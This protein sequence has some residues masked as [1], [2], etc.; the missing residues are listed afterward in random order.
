MR[1]LIP[2][3]LAL[4]MLTACGTEVVTTSD[5]ASATSESAESVVVT[6]EQP[7][8]SAVP[9]MTPTATPESKA[10]VPGQT[11]ISKAV[12]DVPKKEQ[13]VPMATAAPT[14]SPTPVATEAPAPAK[15]PAP[16]AP[17][18]SQ[19]TMTGGSLPLDVAT[20]SDQWWAIDSSDSAYW[21]VADNINAIRAAG[22]LGA[23][24]VDSGLSSAASSR[25]EDF[26]AGGA[27]DHSGMTTKS[28]IC[29]SGGI[30]SASAVCAAWESSSAHYANIMRTDI[31]SMGIGCWFCYYDGGYFT[32]W[33]VTF[34]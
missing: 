10:A 26:V 15:T 21:A 9:T 25:C 17:A 27:F 6:T 4:A 8:H 22:G 3:F 13:L 32:Y 1:K 20:N 16:A 24:S 14:A 23:L 5:S 30:T 33:V 29:A 11:D 12:D 2:I 34:Q 18:V 31:S 19:P 28:E 7:A